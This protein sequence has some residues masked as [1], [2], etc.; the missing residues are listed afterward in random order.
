MIII[1]VLSQDS[2]KG[3]VACQKMA[4]AI[5]SMMKS[6]G[7]CKRS[8]LLSQSFSHAEIECFW[9]M[10]ECFARFDIAEA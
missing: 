7:K 1:D 8:D 10:A 6:N 5:A 9:D 2:S 4:V 3:F